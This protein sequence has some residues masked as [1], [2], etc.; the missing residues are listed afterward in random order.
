MHTAPRRRCR[1]TPGP[2]ATTADAAAVLQP[3][4][5][6]HTSPARPAG[7]NPT[8]PVPTHAPCLCLTLLRYPCS[9]RMAAKAVAGRPS[10]CSPHFC[11]PAS[12]QA[13]T[14]F[15]PPSPRLFAPSSF[16]LPITRI[17]AVECA[18]PALASPAPSPRSTYRHRCPLIAN[19][20]VPWQGRWAFNGSC[21][22]QGSL[23]FAL[24]HHGITLSC[25]VSI[26][27][28]FSDR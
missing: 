7:A 17:I 18:P 14:P 13:H 24:K 9:F 23:G 5:A 1:P 20:P 19:F 10:C 25:L 15:H 3:W 22:R 2:R 4:Y 28:L 12:A 6:L 16:P 21:G 27:H 8:R 11:R 26:H